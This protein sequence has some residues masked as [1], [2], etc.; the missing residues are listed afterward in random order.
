MLNK[1]LDICLLNHIGLNSTS[2]HWEIYLVKRT[3]GG[4]NLWHTNSVFSEETAWEVFCILDLE[5]ERHLSFP[6]KERCLILEVTDMET[7]LEMHNFISLLAH[8]TE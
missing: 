2:F 1:Y 3:D 8:N 7:V 6:L 5:I 4:T